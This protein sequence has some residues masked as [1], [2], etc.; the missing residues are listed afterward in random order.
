MKEIDNFIMALGYALLIGFE[1][2]KTG[3][4]KWQ[5]I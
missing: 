3:W 2:I 5:N 1:Y 4:E